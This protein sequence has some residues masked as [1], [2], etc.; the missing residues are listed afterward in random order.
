MVARF[1]E[2]VLD[3]GA[4]RVGVDADDLVHVGSA[5]SK[6]LLADLLDRDAVREGA[7]RREVDPVTRFERARHAR[8]VH[9]LDADDFT[10]G[11]SRF[12]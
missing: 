7:D 4:H 1:F 6:R 12:T 2:H 10:A 5:D 9:R 8:R 3:R 11:R